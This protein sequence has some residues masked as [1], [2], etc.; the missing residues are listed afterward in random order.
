M[1]NRRD[2]R[3]SRMLHAPEAIVSEILPSRNSL[4]T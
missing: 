2:E 3:V 4:K 1:E